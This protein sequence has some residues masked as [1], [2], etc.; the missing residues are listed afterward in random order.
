M[1][2]YLC[3]ATSSNFPGPCVYVV[4][5]REVDAILKNYEGV[6]KQDCKAKVGLY[7]LAPFGERGRIVR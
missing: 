2:S 3:N 5:G 7:S 1:M 4:M 6:D